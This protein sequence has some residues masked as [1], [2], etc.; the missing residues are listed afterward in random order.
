MKSQKVEQGRD[1]LFHF[2]TR[3]FDDHSPGPGDGPAVTVDFEAVA[4]R[5]VPGSFAD[6][7]LVT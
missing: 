3:R 7:L 2:F 6:G 5:L 4:V 1:S